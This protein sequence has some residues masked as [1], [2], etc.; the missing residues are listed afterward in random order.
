MKAIVCEMCSGNNLI[1]ENG[2]FVCQN[3][4]TKYTVEEARKLMI[5]GPIDVSG[6]IVKIDNSLNRENLFVLSENAFK[7]NNFLEAEQYCNKTLEIDANEYKAWLIKGKA[8]HRQTTLTY[9]RIEEALNCFLEAEHLAPIDQKENVL[10][11]ISEELFG[12][13]HSLV[14]KCCNEYK[15]SPC[16]NRAN[17]I[18]ASINEVLIPTSTVAVKLGIQHRTQ[19][20]AIASYITNL[21]IST[22]NDVYSS[23]T[24]EKYPQEYM[25]LNLVDRTREVTQLVNYSISLIDDDKAKDL[26][27]YISLININS[28]VLR[29]WSYKYSS[30]K[31]K[32]IK[33]NCMSTNEKQIINNMILIWKNK[34]REI[35]PNHQI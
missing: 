22:W 15:N 7:S 24:K 11:Q 2:Y 4:G 25:R 34:I 23:F 10:M 6:S 20:Q 19:M 16:E 30:V 14:R 17:D 29:A 27:R 13:N 8:I 9:N 26:Q 31:H 12:S 28:F 33:D 3:C 18:I 21:S 35:N 1:K 32:Y 5:E